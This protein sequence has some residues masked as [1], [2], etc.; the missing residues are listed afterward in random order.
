[1]SDLA[2]RLRTR[3]LDRRDNPRRLAQ[4]KGKFKTKRVGDKRLPQWQY[5]ITS[6]GRVWFC[7]DK[8]ERIVWVTKVDL[9]HPKET[10]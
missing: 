4:L 7:P 6:A 3:P 8:D 1:M 2:E 5:E 10:E 9:A